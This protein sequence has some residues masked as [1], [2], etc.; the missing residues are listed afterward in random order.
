MA[1]CI[2]T[3]KDRPAMYGA[4]LPASPRISFSNDLA[5]D[6][7][8]PPPRDIVTPD[9]TFEFTVG[10]RP[11][12]AADEL[13]F[14]GR[15]LPLS[16]GQLARVTTLRE[17]LR[18]EGAPQPKGLVRWKEFLGLKRVSSGH[19]APRNSKSVNSST[20]TDSAGEICR[21]IQR[22]SEKTIVL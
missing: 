4:P 13:F 10:G 8:R 5:A 12:I 21:K 9:P 18:A 11:M 6:G 16:S 15:M 14:K 17:E 22:G 7:A 3:L 19:P 2:N 1:S 20:T